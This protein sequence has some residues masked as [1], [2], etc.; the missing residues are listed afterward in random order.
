MSIFD[1]TRETVIDS[2][3]VRRHDTRVTRVQFLGDNNLISESEDGA[4]LSSDA[5]VGMAEQ[6]NPLFPVESEGESQIAE[7]GQIHDQGRRQ[8]AAGGAGRL[9]AV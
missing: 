7:G 1:A 6:E 3:L 8:P 9:L 4:R 5:A 2:P